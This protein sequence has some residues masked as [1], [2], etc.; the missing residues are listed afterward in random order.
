ME[1]LLSVMAMY[2]AI[3]S[4]QKKECQQKSINL[5]VFHVIF[6]RQCHPARSDEHSGDVPQRTKKEQKRDGSMALVSLFCPCCHAVWLLLPHAK[7]LCLLI[8]GKAIF[9]VNIISNTV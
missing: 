8:M 9:S 5:I 2:T 1:D 6:C 7:I 4:T 3:K